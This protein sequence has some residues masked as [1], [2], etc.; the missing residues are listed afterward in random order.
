MQYYND[1][2]EIVNPTSPL[3]IYKHQSQLEEEETT[4]IA[5]KEEEHK[6]ESLMNEG[7]REF[8]HLCQDSLT[9]PDAM[10]D[11]SIT[12]DDVFRFVNE[13]DSASDTYTRYDGISVFIQLEWIKAICG[14]SLGEQSE[15]DCIE[16]LERMSWQQ[17]S[18]GFELH[19]QESSQEETISKIH[20]FCERIFPLIDIKG[21]C[22]VMV[23][24]FILKKINR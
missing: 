10:Y 3:Y 5:Q 14:R 19:K 16:H 13:V 22:H 7:K 15:E 9:S 12:T 21:A 8:V 24:S 2:G 4:A 6:E 17:G 20:G 23:G 1:E 11:G 18:Y